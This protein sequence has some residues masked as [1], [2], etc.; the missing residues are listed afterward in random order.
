LLFISLTSSAEKS[1]AVNQAATLFFG[2][3]RGIAFLRE[4]Y[5]L[6]VIACCVCSGRAAPI[7][8]QALCPTL[9][10]M[11]RRRPNP[12]FFNASTQRQQAC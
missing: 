1:S 9:E 11:R 5:N 10:K 3:P 6:A 12:D 7:E 2:L 4:L 8:P